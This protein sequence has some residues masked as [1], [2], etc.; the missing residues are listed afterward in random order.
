MALI[1]TGAGS[2]CIDEAVAIRLG[3]PIVNV[4]KL[5]SATHSDVP[6]N[7]YP[8]T[9]E[10]AGIRQQL[11]CPLAIGV[12]LEKQKIIALIGR[13]VLSMATVFYN[14]PAGQITLSF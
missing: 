3:L 6:R 2:T 5:T 7:V 12:P 11:D 4:V 9:F 8:V 13:D 1:D 14:G 10:V